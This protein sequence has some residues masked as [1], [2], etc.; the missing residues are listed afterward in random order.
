MKQLN[1]FYKKL[2]GVLLLLCPVILVAQKDRT[3]DIHKISVQDK[4]INLRVRVMENGQYI[5]LKKDMVTVTEQIE[6]KAKEKIEIIAAQPS[7]TY[8]AKTSEVTNENTIILLLDL[9]QEMNSK[10]LLRAQHMIQKVVKEKFDLSQTKIYLTAFGESIYIDRAL[11]TPSNIDQI[12]SECETI[13]EN[14]EKPDFFY[15]LMR[16]VRY[17][18]SL[19]GTKCLIVLGTGKTSYSSQLYQKQL[20]YD[21]NDIQLIMNSLSSKFQVIVSDFNEGEEHFLGCLEGP[22]TSYYE[23]NFPIDDIKISRKAKHILSNVVLKVKPNR[24]IFRGEKRIFHVQIDG[25]SDTRIFRLGSGNYPINI[26]KSLK[27]EQWFFYFTIGVITIFLTFGYGSIIIPFLKEREFIR[28]YVTPYIPEVGV[29]KFDIYY[30]E[31]IKEGEL[32]VKKCRQ[33]TP[34]S[35]WKENEWTCPAYPDCNNQGCSGNGAKEHNNFFRL[36]GIFL[37]MNWILFGVIGG[38]LAWIIISL[39]TK[40]NV[41]IFND[42]IQILIGQNFLSSTS[43]NNPYLIAQTINNEL[44]VG[45]A[46][47][48]GLLFMFSCME[49]RYRFNRRRLGEYIVKIFLRTT[50]GIILTMMVFLIGFQLQYILGL[51]IYL[52]GLITWGLLGVCVGITL[53]L[54]S[55]VNMM[56]GLLG[57]GIASTIAFHLHW[58]ISE[59]S[60][61]E[62]IAIT[63][64]SMVV[65]GGLMGALIM[66][67]ATQIENYELRVMTPFGAQSTIPINKWLKKSINVMIGKSPDSYIHVKWEDDEVKHE[68]AELFLEK[69]KVFIR[70]LEELLVNNRIIT[71]STVLK[72]EDIIQLGRSSITKFKFIANSQKKIN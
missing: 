64:M 22:N 33:I 42:F 2:W 28:K 63:L 20:P 47:G 40:I 13:V 31:E 58:F 24:P 57:G 41:Q 60:H 30:N 70:P 45:I 29:K 71:S 11:V 39:V 10:A 37:K 69:G 68:H 44:I 25:D 12:L 49:S 48:T 53:S 27:W 6:G 35:T 72:N 61:I 59:F 65:M 55:S 56:N 34:F 51:G 19:S 5:S 36:E 1:I 32:I 4:S 26:S 18:K 15:P 17:L 3:I 23:N 50:I 66:N 52:S 62:D 7:V 54:N 16:E 38:V 21:C 14:I 43:G 8:G 46:F 67:V 9:S